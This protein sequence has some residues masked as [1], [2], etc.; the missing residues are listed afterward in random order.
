L[1]WKTT[2][3]LTLQSYYFLRDSLTVVKWLNSVHLLHSW[4]GLRSAYLSWKASTELQFGGLGMTHSM[5]KQRGLIY[6]KCSRR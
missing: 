3:F 6:K 2:Y 4:Q 5:L 1:S